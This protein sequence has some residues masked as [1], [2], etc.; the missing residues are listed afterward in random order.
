M[1]GSHTRLDGQA[2]MYYDVVTDSGP[3]KS[4]PPQYTQDTQQPLQ[5]TSPQPYDVIVN[6]REHEGFGFIIVSSLSKVG[7]VVGEFCIGTYQPMSAPLVY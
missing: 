7:A 1:L 6:R 3:T 4:T 5:Q 2:E